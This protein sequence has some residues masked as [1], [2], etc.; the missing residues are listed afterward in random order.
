MQI[1]S[2]TVDR[3]L[4]AQEIPRSFENQGP[5]PR[6]RKHEIGPYIMKLHGN[7]SQVVAFIE[8]FELEY[9]MCFP[10]ASGV[11]LVGLNQGLDEELRMSLRWCN[12]RAKR[13]DRQ[14][15]FFKET[16]VGCRC[17]VETTTYWIDI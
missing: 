1:I 9:C 8:V 15:F 2:W 13:K 10:S 7:I 14:E 16:L 5:L 6:S 3:C 12:W 4:H 17:I 11:R